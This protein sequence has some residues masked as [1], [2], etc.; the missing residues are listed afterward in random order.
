MYLLIGGFPWFPSSFQSHVIW[1]KNL[2][3]LTITQMSDS[4]WISELEQ[5]VLNILKMCSSKFQFLDLNVLM[6][7]QVLVL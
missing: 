5:Q 2:A 1:I 6:I 4:F 3:P 7:A